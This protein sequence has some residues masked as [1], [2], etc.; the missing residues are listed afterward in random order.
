MEMV[1]LA[2]W[3]EQ[4][5]ISIALKQQK[6]KYIILESQTVIYPYSR[7]SFVNHSPPKHYLHSSDKKLMTFL[8]SIK[9]VGFKFALNLPAW[10]IKYFSDRRKKRVH[11][12]DKKQSVIEPIASASLFVFKGIFP[13]PPWNRDDSYIC[14]QICRL[15]PRTTGLIF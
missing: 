10:W 2:T 13:L 12:Q 7:C 4:W 6:S 1:N 3:F 9:Q 8:Q 5:I 14:L 15:G 11:I